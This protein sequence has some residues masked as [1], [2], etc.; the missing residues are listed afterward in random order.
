MIINRY[1]AAIL[2][3]AIV[4]ITGFTVLPATAFVDAA[5]VWATVVGLATLVVQAI[6]TYLVPLTAGGWQAGLKVG[7]SVALAILGAIAQ[8]V[9]AGHFTPGIVAL[10]VLAGL[11]A[12][13]AQVGVSAR[14]DDPL[15]NQ[16]NETR[17]P[18]T[19]AA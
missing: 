10:I 14:L 9:V 8:Y 11:N 1:L 13:A 6:A 12:L 18:V 3:I 2:Q 7:V 17:P 4:V 19:P 15:L 5:A 16:K